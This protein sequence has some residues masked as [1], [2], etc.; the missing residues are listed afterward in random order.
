MNDEKELSYRV[1]GNIL[2]D[3]STIG[4]DGMSTIVAFSNLSAAK[5]T[6]S[7]PHALI[8]P[9]SGTV[10]IGNLIL[11][12]EHLELCLKHLMDITKDAKPEEFI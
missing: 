2:N 12:V 10:K 8:L 7:D 3:L 4:L 1:Y 11:D 9:I 6:M 5:S